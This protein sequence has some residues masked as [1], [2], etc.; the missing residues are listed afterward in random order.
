MAEELSSSVLKKRLA[1]WAI[2]QALPD[3]EALKP[4]LKSALVSVALA[5]AAGTLAVIGLMAAFAALYFYMIDIGMATHVSLAFVGAVV[6]LLAILLYSYARSKVHV[7]ANISESTALFSHAN[8]HGPQASVEDDSD[9][10]PD[11]KA[12][13][14]DVNNPNEIVGEIV[15]DVVGSFIDGIFSKK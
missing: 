8:S 15:S 10:I 12:L 4:H 13:T 14:Y 5:A 9:E 11:N 7:V 3:S 6:L 1:I 2:G